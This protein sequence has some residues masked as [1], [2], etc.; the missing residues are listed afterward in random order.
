MTPTLE[1][2][3]LILR[4]LTLDDAPAAQRL[5]PHWEIVRFLGPRVPWPY[6]DDGSLAF[7]RDVALP[8]V[9]RGEQWIWAITLKDGPD[10][11]IGVINLAAG[12]AESRGFWLGLPWHGQGLMTEAC[13]PV[14]GF[15]FDGLDQP[16]LRV[17]K[18]APNVAS[19][20]VSQKQG[21]RLIGMETRSFV[22]GRW[23]AEVW[24]ITREE[25]R[26]HAKPSATASGGGSFRSWPQIAPG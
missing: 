20:R 10:H 2:R 6:P 25:W 16:V 1:T 18:A 17:F 3:R 8:A 24:E 13:E 21:M 4:P 23:P 26:A 9:E 22:S 11:M 12:R 15:W 5:F 7:F 19:S 14:T